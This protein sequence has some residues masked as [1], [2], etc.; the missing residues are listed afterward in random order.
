MIRV[1]QM[2]KLLYSVLFLSLIVS[3][4]FAVEAHAATT[5]HV[6]PTGSDTNTL[7]DGTTPQKAFLTIQK[8][9]D[10]A[11]SGDTI[12]VMNGT[13]RPASGASVA[14]FNSTKSGI[15]LKAYP[16]HFPV[17]KALKAD[18]SWSLISIAS[19]NNITIEGLELAGDVANI[20]LTEAQNLKNQYKVQAR[21]QDYTKDPT[22]APTNTCITWNNYAYINT[23]A[24]DIKRASSTAA[25]P[26][27]I[28]I[29]GNVVHD[30]PGAGIAATSGDYMTIEKNKVYN[31]SRRGFFA[32]S[33]ISLF[34]LTNSDTNTDTVGYKN[35]VR[36][37]ITYSNKSEIGW[38]DQELKLENNATSPS[39]P[40]S[41]YLS[42]G[43][44]IIIDDNM[45]EQDTK[46]KYLGRTLVV[47]NVS[48]NN[49][50]AGINIFS[51]RF[52]DVINNTTYSNG[53][54]QNGKYYQDGTTSLERYAELT[55]NKG[56]DYYVYNN[57]TK[58]STY[59]NTAFGVSNA[60]NVRFN[61]NSFNGTVN[62]TMPTT[63]NNNLTTDPMFENAA[64]GD[65][66]L[67][68]GSPAINSGTATKA[69]ATDIKGTA[70]PQGSGYDRGAYEYVT[71]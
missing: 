45:H 25:V 64:G 3:V 49:G 68:L 11:V 65:F 13:Y 70:R 33:G 34:H 7:N 55:V 67:K 29:R 15:T 2:S 39:K 22:C 59:G 60:T 40:I 20:T 1:H 9:I 8:A 57:I 26:H 37:N 46:V 36:N 21:K 71:P 69:P 47:N 31:T 48:Y 58:S 66:R 28:V 16:G 43:N 42:D 63:N 54:Q 56:D 51:S 41:N 32:T 30:L 17:L 14:S 4:G 38:A 44:G 61:W 19:A 12:L 35:Y 5:Y 27:H 52:V 6:S 23:S 53:Q 62:A 10:K 18:N 24:V 50:G